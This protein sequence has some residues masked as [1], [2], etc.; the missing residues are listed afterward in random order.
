MNA[1]TMPSEEPPPSHVAARASRLAE[2]KAVSECT[3]CRERE[4]L[5]GAARP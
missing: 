5:R 3:E 1:D 2:A 4:P